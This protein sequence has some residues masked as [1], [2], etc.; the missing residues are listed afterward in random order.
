MSSSRTSVPARLL[1]LALAAGT[2]LAAGL[3]AAPA[4]AATTAPTATS[5]TS[6]QAD[7]VDNFDSLNTSRW[8][9]RNN[10]YASTDTN[11]VLSR[12]TTIDNGTLRI[13]AKKESAG[14]R[15]YTSGYVDSIGKYT[16]PNYFKAEI[17]AKVPFQQGITAAPLWLRPADGGDGEIDLLNTYGNERANPLVHQAIHTGYTN[18]RVASATKSYAS[19]GSTASTDWHTYTIEKTPHAITMWTDGVVTAT[20][21]PSTTS[22]FDQYYEAGKRWNLRINLPVG[23]STT[24]QPDSSTSWSGD[25]TAMRVD[26]L[27]TWTVASTTT[28]PTP[29]PAPSGWKADAV[30]DFNAFDTTRWRKI[31]GLAS[32]NESSYVLARNSTIDNGTLRIQAKKESAGGRSYTSGYV[33]SIGRYTLPNYFRAEVR[34]KV[35]FTQGLWAAPLWFRPA[36]NSGGEIDLIETFGKEQSKPMTHQTIHTAYGSSHQQSVF[37]KLYS[38]LNAGAATDWHTYTVEKKPGS[39]TMWTDG[40]QT[41][42]WTTG[43]PSWFN[44]YYEAG[45]RWNLRINLQVGGGWGGLPDGTTNWSPDASAMKIDYVKTWVPS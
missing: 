45:K 15:A 11:Y 8:N 33:D 12:N 34:A 37:T 4:T 24:G 25:G 22:W 36:D 3:S 21:T 41:A 32:S 2:C 29:A 35:P 6:W 13:Q 9:V 39:I 1:A 31:D 28:T 19:L 38:L 43:S 42:R 5:A 16:L 40:V 7:V 14:G 20:F 26:Y 23:T 30:E 27:K 18:H 44:Q 17:R 10:T